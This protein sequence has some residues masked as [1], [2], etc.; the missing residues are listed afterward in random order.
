MGA[1]FEGKVAIITGAAKGMGQATAVEMARGGAAV[2]ITDIDAAG[3]EETA[4][5]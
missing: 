1:R 4:A 2:V 5:L 3:L